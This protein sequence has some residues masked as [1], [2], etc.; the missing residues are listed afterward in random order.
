MPTQN[1][2][3]ITG[4]CACGA[5]RY[6]IT[7]APVMMFKC[8]CRDCQHL[9]GSGYAPAV[10]VPATAF[11]FTRGR[12]RYYFTQSAMGGRHKR[13]FCAECGSTI[14]GGESDEPTELVGVVAGSLD[15][16]S[17]FRPNM[18]IFVCDAQPW[19]QMDPKIQKFEQG[20]Q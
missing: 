19:D 20:P 10:L 4:G 13:G 1:S 12:P 7:A 16:P 2:N 11:R 6:E 3:T 5:I 15:D 14:T 18:D 17:L 8:H 9:S